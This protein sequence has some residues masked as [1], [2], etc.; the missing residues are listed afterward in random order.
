LGMPPDNCGTVNNT[1]SSPHHI[2][3]PVLFMNVP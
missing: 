3:S 1:P 2:I